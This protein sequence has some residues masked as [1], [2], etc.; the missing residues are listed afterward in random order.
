MFGCGSRDSDRPLPAAAPFRTGDS[1][2][3][4]GPIAAETADVPVAPQPHPE[5]WFEDITARSGVEFVYR[6]GREGGHF[7][8]LETVGG[9]AA[10]FDFDQD[11]DL[12][13]F[14]AAGGDVSRDTMQVS[15][16]TPGL[17]L[18]EGSGTFVDATAA[19]DLAG[20][21]DYSH[22][23]AVADYDRDG[24]PDLLL[25]C[26]GRSRL[27]RND[28]GK[29]F[30]DAT[31][32][33]RLVVDGWSTAAAWAD[34]DRD[35]WPDLYIAGYVDWKPSPGEWCGDRAANVRDVC[36]PQ[37]YPPAADR[38]FRNLGN[39]TFEECT[40]RA[41]LGTPSRGL[42]VLAADFNLDG[43][44]DFYV[45]NDGNDNQ[46]YL[47]GPGLKFREVGVISGTATNEFGVPEGS[48]GID[49]GDVNG[50]GRGDLFVTNFEMEDNALYLAEAEA[51]FAHATVRFRLGGSSRPFVGFGT[52][53]ADF[54]LDGDLDL[55]VI[56][57]N[58]F[59]Q[60]GQAPYTQPAFLY[61]NADG[62]FFEDVTGRAGPWFRARHAGRGA[63]VGD[64]DDDGAL[65]LIVVRQDQPVAVLRNRGSPATPWLRVE[66]VGTRSAVYPVG[67]RVSYAHRG[68]RLVRFACAG[69]GYLSHNDPR[70]LLPAETAAEN[71]TVEVRWPDGKTETFAGLQVGRTNRLVEGAGHVE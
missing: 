33:S 4:I 60:T 1:A 65:D 7:T 57:G 21:I 22:G 62:E 44:I 55:F 30:E 38:L 25:T 29:R 23:C 18:N 5:D 70:I 20:G 67:S 47:G 42:G 64:I 39:G 66:L 37:S 54:D 52:G 31:E 40:D 13:L 58:V 11:G 50:D 51:G 8:L 10:L 43:W 24:F 69:A 3:L 36:P 56:N 26:Y 32:T 12:D 27:F 46:L 71:L 34:V 14:V 61:R 2:H 63:A 28:G 35:G 16:R 6:S 49:Y 45:A 48:M 15:G 19:I 59:Y 41:G 53:F 68:R 9:G 17:F